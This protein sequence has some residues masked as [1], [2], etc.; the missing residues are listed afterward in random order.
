MKKRSRGMKEQ[1]MISWTEKED[2]EEL[3]EKSWG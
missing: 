1:I 3:R 2:G